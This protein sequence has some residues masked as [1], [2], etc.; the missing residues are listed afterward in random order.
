MKNI[1]K[2]R[3][4]L[5]QPVW[6]MF[7]R[8][9]RPRVQLRQLRQ[10]GR[11]LRLQRPRRQSQLRHR[12][13]SRTWLLPF[14]EG[15]GRA[16]AEGGERGN[17]LVLGLG[18]WLVAFAVIIGLAGVGGL[19]VARQ[20]LLA[21]ADSLALSAAN[22]INDAAYYLPHGTIGPEPSGGRV[23]TSGRL[24]PAETEVWKIARAGAG[25]AQVVAPTGVEGNGVVVTLEK[26]A[27]VPLFEFTVTLQATARAE[28]HLG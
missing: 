4:R 14:A 24:R 20:D 15:S 9:R 1:R 21:R 13:P 25:E 8:R 23:V 18:M 26:P 10:H 22:S 2:K 12:P 19:Y 28:L 11:H 7:L 17:L 5:A 6:L 16:D 27:T 3:R